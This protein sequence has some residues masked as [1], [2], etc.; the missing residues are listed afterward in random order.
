MMGDA[1]EV[2]DSHL[3]TVGVKQLDRGAGD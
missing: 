1:T 3:R 2:D